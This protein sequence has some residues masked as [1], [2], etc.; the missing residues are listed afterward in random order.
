MILLAPRPTL[1]ETEAKAEKELKAGNPGKALV[2]YEAAI[3]LARDNYT[4]LRL[5]DAYRGAGWAEPRPVSPREHLVLQAHIRNE[6]ARVWRGAADNFARQKK[7]HA[8][9]LTRRAIIEL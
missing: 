9:I 5:R 1:H 8:A 3:R 2:L 7:V 4:K 6:K